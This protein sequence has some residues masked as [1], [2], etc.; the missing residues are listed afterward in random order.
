MSQI[1]QYL[2]SFQ[3]LQSALLVP[4]CGAASMRA[5]LEDTLLHH[6]T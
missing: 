2:K 5:A 3:A 4:T 6:C 1:I